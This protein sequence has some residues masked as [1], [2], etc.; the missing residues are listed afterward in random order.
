[1]GNAYSVDT[2]PQGRLELG[3]LA[4]LVFGRRDKTNPKEK[5]TKKQPSVGKRSGQDDSVVAHSSKGTLDPGR[6]ERWLRRVRCGPS[7]E[8]GVVQAGE[9]VT[10][11]R[12]IWD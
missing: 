10:A 6:L 7:D 11:R 5:K 2:G 8:A 3:P 12:R 4:D 9:A 1:M